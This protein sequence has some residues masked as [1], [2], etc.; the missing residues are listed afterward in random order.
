ME[1]GKRAVVQFVCRNVVV[2]DND[3]SEAKILEQV[4]EPFERYPTSLEAMTGLGGRVTDTCAI[5]P[6]AS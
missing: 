5:T 4:L 3:S 6:I 1:V 2:A